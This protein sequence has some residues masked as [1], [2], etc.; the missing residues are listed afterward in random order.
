M[1][2]WIQIKG[3]DEDEDFPDG[4]SYDVLGGGVLKVISG[5]DIHLYSPGCWQHVTVDTRPADER[6][7]LA[8]PVNE[9]A[10]WQ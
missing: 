2:M 7:E 9:D 4:A 3:R 6:D 8:R 10:R 5:N 1:K